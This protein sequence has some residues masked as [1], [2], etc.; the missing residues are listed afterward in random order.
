[1]GDM[2]GLAIKFYLACAL[3]LSVVVY[4]VLRLLGWHPLTT[5]GYWIGL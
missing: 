3:F 5:I 2:I 1:M 4:G